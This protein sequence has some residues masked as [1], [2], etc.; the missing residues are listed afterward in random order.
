MHSPRLSALL[1]IAACVLPIRSQPVR[2]DVLSWPSG[3]ANVDNVQGAP[4]P[5]QNE[6][7]IVGRLH[8]EVSTGASRSRVRYAIR[9]DR[10]GALEA[11]VA[12]GGSTELQPHVG[13]LIAAT[14][15]SSADDG[16]REQIFQVQHITSLAQMPAATS[17]QRTTRIG[18][19]ALASCDEVIT[20]CADMPV[21]YGACNEPNCGEFGLCGPEHSLWAD[22]QY[23]HW[24]TDGMSIPPLV[25]TSPAGT[26]RSEVGV[27]GQPGTAILLGNQ[28]VLDGSRSG[29]RVR[30]GGWLDQENLLGIQGEYFGLAE[31]SDS[32]TFTSDSRGRPLLARPFF[33]VNPRNPFTQAFDPPAREDAEL[34]SYP[35]VLRGSV[36]VG[37]NTRLNAAGVAVRANV[38]CESCGEKSGSQY[39]RIDLLAGYRF[40]QLKDRL[41]ITEDLTSLDSLNP[42]SFDIVDQFGTRNDFNGAD[43]GLNWNT[44]WDRW[45]LDFLLRTAF[46]NT[47]QVVDIDGGTTIFVP[48][49]PSESFEGGLL[50]QGSNIGHYR[51][52]RFSVVPEI[53]ITLGYE[54]LPRWRVTAGY[55]LLYWTSVARAGDQIDLDVNPDQLAPPLD[56]VEGALRPAF[57]FRDV[58]FWG[59]GIN[60]GVE[61]RW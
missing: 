4:A 20:D 32:F 8:R 44:G 17:D 56:P 21:G 47:H 29:I 59:Q 7:V 22:V 28:D 27:L 2:A 38:A 14:V 53:A 9:N 11:Y 12:A 50:A 18:P 16:N 15:E 36:A 39:S 43:L 30:L 61:G 10:T 42:V 60:L 57:A 19:I 1:A 58:G 49:V 24:W 46:G 40:L 25:T 37:V 3:S 48:N 5:T 13:K 54:V 52:D 35:D 55:T 34:V 33:N 31:E 41:Q 45:S 23:L 51:R 6:Y 26:P